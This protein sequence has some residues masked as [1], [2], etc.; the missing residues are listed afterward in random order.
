MSDIVYKMS[1]NR[2]EYKYTYHFKDIYLFYASVR[3]KV[4][5]TED[6]ALITNFMVCSII[7][8]L[9]GMNNLH[10]QAEMVFMSASQD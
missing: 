6:S 4:S 1:T 7:V 2:K 9:F 3:F 10:Q 5:G 8:Y